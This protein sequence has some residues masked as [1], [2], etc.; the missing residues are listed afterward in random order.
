ML[1]YY[2]II[3]VIT[4]AVWGID[5]SQ[6]VQSQ[7]RVPERWLAGLTVLGGAFGALAGMSFFRHKTRKI[8]FWIMGITCCVIHAIL[9]L[10]FLIRT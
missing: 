4:F 10:Q 6:A 7:W 9:I 1:L 2:M 5:K 3:N 8:L